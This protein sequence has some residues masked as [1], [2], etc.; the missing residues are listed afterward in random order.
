M[1]NNGKILAQNQ[2]F[3]YNASKEMDKGVDRI[4]FS[5]IIR[6]GEKE[7]RKAGDLEWRQY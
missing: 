2:T 3:S 4:Y 1:R 7:G 5:A 6:V